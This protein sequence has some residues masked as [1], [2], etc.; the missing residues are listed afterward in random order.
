MLDILDLVNIL[1]DEFGNSFSI[2]SD[3]H[4]QIN[5]KNHTHNIWIN[6]HNHIK[7][8]LSGWRA[9]KIAKNAYDIISYVREYDHNQ[10]NDCA[11]STAYELISFIS[12]AKAKC[13]GIKESIFVD[14]GWKNGRGK[15]SVAYVKSEHDIEAKTMVV[16]AAD[17]N[18]AEYMAI[19]AGLGYGDESVPVFCDNQAM[20]KKANNARVKWIPRHKN[21]FADKLASLKRK[22]KP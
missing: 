10:P 6:K 8:K 19:E 12:I 13:D 2:C 22:R 17:A 3:K 21:G 15:I 16:D 18:V 14:A 5:I 7:F 1:A 20:V 11:I 9:A 4:F